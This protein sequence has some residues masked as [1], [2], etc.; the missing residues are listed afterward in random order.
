MKNIL[1]ISLMLVTCSLAFVGCS[2]TEQ[3]GKAETAAAPAKAESGKVRIA[4]QP[5]V[6]GMP[7]FVAEQQKYFAAH[8]VAE[9][10]KSFTSANDMIN[11][12]VAGEVEIVPGAPLVPVLSLESQYPGRF[13]VFAHSV[14]TLD[15]P[16]DLILVKK[17]SPIKTVADL[18]GKKLALIPGTTAMNAMKAYLKKNNVD[19]ASINYVQLAPPSQLSA[20]Q[21]DAVDALYAYEPTV[22]IALD[23]GGYRAISPSVYCSLQNP[24]ALVVSIIDRK[25]EKANPDTAKRA[26]EA[27][28]DAVKLMRDDPVKASASLAIYTKVDPKITSK[29]SLQNMT[30][31]G[32][33]DLKSLQQ[34]IDIL[35]DIGEIKTKVAA[36][37]LVAPTR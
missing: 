6:F 29:V 35:L 37:N 31:A 17:D 15:K 23:Q 30:T 8:G 26:I 20:L 28:D 7:V 34:F 21:A 27:L 2:K 24:C 14:M 16:F 36:E 5:I 1:K 22:T 11:A 4:Y 18:A 9:E 12:L 32:K 25:F 10:S 19:S 3:S 13:R 33:M